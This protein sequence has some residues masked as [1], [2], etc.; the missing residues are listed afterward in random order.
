MAEKG[1]EYKYL[2]EVAG[3]VLA[4][5]V[6]VTILSRLFSGV[7]GFFQNRGVTTVNDRWNE[8]LSNLFYF[9]S[10]LFLIF[11]IA[12]NIL[13]TL[14]LMGIIYAFIR[15]SELN[16]EI[17][18]KFYPPLRPVE[19]PPGTGDTEGSP[20]RDVAYYMQPADR[21]TPGQK[22]WERIQ[23]FINSGNPSDW[24]IAILEADTILGQI[25]ESMRLPGDSI[26][27][28]LKA[29]EKSDFVTLEQ[30]WEAHKIRNAVAHQGGEFLISEREAKRVI[31]LYEAVFREFDY[32]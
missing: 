1:N 31:G 25:L 5:Y 29:V 18:E 19:V 27:E 20:E 14:F 3:V 15:I 22:A 17:N 30:A 9:F 8:I 4:L 32:I 23:E 7:S 24:R 10:A 21:V 16:Q 13:S 2:A 6:V 11:T 26:G 28:K 12:S